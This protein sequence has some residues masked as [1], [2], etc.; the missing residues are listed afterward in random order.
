MLNIEIRA[1]KTFPDLRSVHLDVKENRRLKHAN[2]FLLLLMATCPENPISREDWL[3]QNATVVK[4]G[5]ISN[6]NK[7]TLREKKICRG[8]RFD[9]VNI[10]PT[11]I[12]RQ[13]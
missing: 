3:L 7:G 4:K 2:M 11:N 9:R 6:I 1:K 8:A 10:A 12:G 13:S 5:I